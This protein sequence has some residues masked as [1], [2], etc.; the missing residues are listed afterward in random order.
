MR[1][2]AAGFAALGV[3]GVLARTCG[4]AG[5]RVVVRHAERGFDRDAKGAHWRAPFFG[6]SRI[7]KTRLAKAMSC[8]CSAPD[9]AAMP[10]DGETEISVITSQ[11]DLEKAA[12]ARPG[13]AQ[14]KR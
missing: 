13:P 1:G 12:A 7:E 6:V 4:R 3:D 11:T 14:W 2:H 10:F 5:Q 9:S 8:R